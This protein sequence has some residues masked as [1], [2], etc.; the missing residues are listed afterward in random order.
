MEEV[1]RSWIIATRSKVRSKLA[2]AFWW[3]DLNWGHL[4]ISAHDDVAEEGTAQDVRYVDVPPT[5][6]QDGNDVP[7]STVAEPFTRTRDHNVRL[8]HYEDHP[9]SFLGLESFI[10]D[11]GDERSST[12]TATTLGCSSSR[13]TTIPMGLCSCTSGLHLR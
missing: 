7:T 4:F 10:L 12:P 13:K 1:L 8:Y 3:L 5:R 9:G 11:S 2:S 6:D